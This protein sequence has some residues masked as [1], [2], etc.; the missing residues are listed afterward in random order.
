MTSRSDG[1]PGAPPFPL[2]QP[3]PA[4]CSG[5]F[6]SESF[7]LDS[8]F[9]ADSEW[10]EDIVFSA[11]PCVWTVIGLSETPGWR[12]S[13]VSLTRGRAHTPTRL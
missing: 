10:M 6:L 2:K 12:S 1:G 7:L 13:R 8:V 5:P 11:H 3:V 4:S 9:K